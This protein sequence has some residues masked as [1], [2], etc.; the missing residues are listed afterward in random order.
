MACTAGNL[1][2]I[3]LLLCCCSAML[4][5]ELLYCH[6]LELL[7]LLHLGKVV[8]TS[9]LLLLAHLTQLLVER[10]IQYSLA[11]ITSLSTAWPTSHHTTR[12][13]L[14]AQQLDIYACY[15]V[16]AVAVRI[17]ISLLYSTVASVMPP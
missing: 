11:H 7:H 9:H 6:H 1:L 10:R 17:C 2:V 15:S 4:H 16:S 8:P 13:R 12:T 5:L 14:A 3:C